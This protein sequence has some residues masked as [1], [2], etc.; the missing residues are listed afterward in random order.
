MKKKEYQTIQI[1]IHTLKTEDIITTSNS[2]PFFGDD[3]PLTPTDDLLT[4]TT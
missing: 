4:P 2:L 1:V 3:D